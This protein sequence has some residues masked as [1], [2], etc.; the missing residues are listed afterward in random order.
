M[1]R[2][3]HPGGSVGFYLHAYVSYVSSSL[4][5]V[6]LRVQTRRSICCMPATRSEYS[7]SEARQPSNS[8]AE[9]LKLSPL[10][11]E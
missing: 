11:K 2:K 7:S 1:F 4:F 8:S 3:S 9:P 6:Y 5:R 10:Q